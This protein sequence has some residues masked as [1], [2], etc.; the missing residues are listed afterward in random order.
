MRSQITK[1]TVTIFPEGRIDS[2]NA[3][4]IK[5]KIIEC[6]ESSDCKSVIIDASNLSYISSAGLRVVLFLKK[7]YD[8]VI[9]NYLEIVDYVVFERIESNINSVAG[10]LEQMY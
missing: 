9:G 2:D 10:I 3:E 1:K 5:S 4:M 7:K 8:D 6:I